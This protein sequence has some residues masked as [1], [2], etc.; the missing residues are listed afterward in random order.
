M[1]NFIQNIIDAIVNAGAA[2]SSKTPASQ[3]GGSS[4]NAAPSASKGSAKATSYSYTG[5]STSSSSKKSGSGSTSKGSGSSSGGGTSNASKGGNGVPSYEIKSAV[6]RVRDIIDSTGS[7]SKNKLVGYD[8]LD[9]EADEAQNKAKNAEKNYLDTLEKSGYNAGDAKVKSAKQMLDDALREAKIYSAASKNAPAAPKMAT[10]NAKEYYEK[11]KAG[12]ADQFDA[13]TSLLLADEGAYSAKRTEMLTDAT[14]EEKEKL[15]QLQKLD[16]QNGTNEAE[17]YRREIEAR[18]AQERGA[19]KAKEIQVRDGLGKVLSYGGQAVQSGFGKAVNDVAKTLGVNT[20]DKTQ[21]EYTANILKQDL[22]E[23]G[24]NIANTGFEVAQGIGAMIPSLVAASVNPAA[25]LAG[26]AVQGVTS[27]ASAYQDKLAEGWT[28]GDAATYGLL[29][30]ASEVALS[31]ALGG[32][33]KLGGSKSLSALSKGLTERINNSLGRAVANAS[34]RAAAEGGEEALQTYIS[35]AIESVIRSVPYNAPEFEEV[36]HNAIVGAATSAVLGTGE[37]VSDIRTAPARSVDPAVSATKLLAD[38]KTPEQR[39]NAIASMDFGEASAAIESGMVSPEEMPF[40][41]VSPDTPATLINFA[42]ADNLPIIMDYGNVY[43]STKKDGELR[44]HYHDLGVDVMAEIPE[45]LNDPI[46]MVKL[47][48]GRINEVLELEDKQGRKIFVSIELSATRRNGKNY[49]AYNLVL[50]A[51]GAKD[52]YINNILSNPNNTV[53]I[54]KMSDTDSQVNSRR[55]KLPGIIIE[56]TSDVSEDI[57]SD[58]NIPTPTPVVN[59]QSAGILRATQSVNNTPE[60]IDNEITPAITQE[61]ENGTSGEFN[62][63]TPTTAQTTMGRGPERERG[64]S[65]SDRANPT[66]S[67]ELRAS[68]EADPEVYT[69]LTNAEVTEKANAIL[70]KGFDDAYQDVLAAVKAA[71]KGKKLAPEYAVAGHEI[72][73]IL[74]SSD[75]LSEARRLKADIYAEFTAAGQL[76]QIS[77]L[78]NQSDPVTKALTIERLVDKLNES[79]TKGQK[80]KN[81]KNEVGTETGGIKVSDELIAKFSNA[82]DDASRDAAMNAIE[83]EIARQ[84]PPT[85]RERFTALRYLNMLGNFKTQTRNITG[86]ALAAVA[87]TA[88]RRVQAATELGAAL[89]TGGKYERNTALFV[90]PELRKAASADFAKVEAEAI[91][92]AKYSDVGRQLSRG[93]EEKRQILPGVLEK[94]R[95]GTNW[96]MNAG[97]RGFLKFHYADALAGWM[98]AHG[99]SDISQASPEQ[100]AQGR[101]FA[102]KE[103]QE[104]TFR[105]SNAVSDF[106]S[107]IGRGEGTPEVIKAISEGIMPFR[108]TPANVA[109]RA[110]EYS[111]VGLF[112]TATFDAYR[113]AIGDM[114]AAEVINDVAKGATGT[115]LAAA[116]YL[117]A[118]AGLAKGSE[119][120]DELAAFQKTQGEM[121]YSIKIG[122]KYVSL[123]QFAPMAVPFFMGVKLQEILEAQEGAVSLDNV[124][125]LLGCITDPMLEMSMLSG[126]NDAFDNLSSA[127]GD[128][129]ALPQLVINAMMSYW[130]QGLTNSFIGQIEQASEKNRQTIYNENATGFDR[131]LGSS[132]YKVGQFMAKIPGRDYHQQDY[133]DAWGRTQSTGS[134]GE[135]IYNSFLNPTYSSKNRSTEV[136]AELER[137]YRDNKNAEDFPNVFPQKRSRSD[138]YGDGK[139]MTADEYLQYSKDSGNM[140]LELVTDFMESEQYGLLEDSQKAEVISNLYKFA[141]DRALKKVKEAN[142]VNAAST[143]DD[144]AELPNLPAYLSAKTAYADAAD[145]N[146]ESPNY[147]A[148]DAVLAALPTMDRATRDK[149]DEQSGFK[150]LRFA[151]EVYGMDSAELFGIKNLLKTEQAS[152]LMGKDSGA[153]DAAVISKKFE[154][155]DAE[156]IAALETQNLPYAD[157]GKRRSVVRRFEAAQTENISFDEWAK[158]EAYVDATKTS[159]TP[160]KATIVAAGEKYGYSGSLVYQIY[161]KISADEDTVQQTNDYFHKDYVEPVDA[162]LAAYLTGEDAPDAEAAKKSGGGFGRI[163]GGRSWSPRPADLGDSVS[164]VRSIA[165]KGTTGGSSSNYLD[166][167]LRQYISAAANKIGAEPAVNWETLLASYIKNAKQ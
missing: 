50:T 60:T 21:A 153:S 28:Q 25:P 137:L 67:E 107:K 166:K 34:I 99:I 98:Q 9:W 2:G 165:N 11:A 157:T 123:S 117:L 140:K 12:N 30:A 66:V 18:I 144:E 81:I 86:N 159:D 167:A 94:Y 100:L 57:P 114:S 15:V 46:I 85:F 55:N 128:A 51:F 133:V 103:A 3:K 105:D 10:F 61:A 143:W 164:A 5:K 121:D 135:R 42:D 16:K 29:E 22:E 44:G 160:N 163:R 120:D 80:R 152:G 102:I 118:Q 125:G 39:A 13:S 124:E 4:G 6:D 132:Q 23:S 73:N 91:G 32:I 88:K 37:F 75:R 40:A 45:K 154:G 53:L 58:T 156:K 35:P 71:K 41:V 113:A 63:A 104:A 68:L 101:A 155:T 59:T 134:T 115:A 87:S 151:S 161:K 54:N 147:K 83:A 148:V 64:G 162:D 126:V 131:F 145:I 70:R 130:M 47:D 142:D 56:S 31:S 119:E 150:N 26:R 78:F 49:D 20:Q 33:S 82:A 36:L 65:A 109:V 84:I 95:R 8:M 108:K 43:L 110:V 74:A 79:L 116:G 24:S 62:T 19:N 97:D 7:G 149:L 106:V 48:N 76:A 111:P 139:L 52:N 112:K 92:E 14:A 127:S 122:D 129:D 141:D 93:I 38:A 1:A 27:A 69:Q 96:I 77:R 90:S 17:A 72:A 89:A 146:N 158:I 138:V 136:D